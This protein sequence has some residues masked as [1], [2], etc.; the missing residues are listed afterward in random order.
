MWFSFSYPLG[1]LVICTESQVLL[2]HALRH[3]SLSNR[4]TNCCEPAHI[5]T[6]ITTAISLHPGPVP[7]KAR[8]TSPLR[9]AI[10]SICQRAV[11]CVVADSLS[12]NKEESPG[13][14]AGNGYLRMRPIEW[15][16]SGR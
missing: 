12:V 14:G 3:Q 6:E 15:G 11:N 4:S 2:L 5:A 1:L 13:G 8:T 9:N 16:Q 10:V 7:R